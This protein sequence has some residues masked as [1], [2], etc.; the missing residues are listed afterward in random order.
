MQK[1][2]TL[3]TAVLFSV[4]CFAQDNSALDS[5]YGVLSVQS[6]VPAGVWLNGQAV[7]NTPLSIELSAGW[8]IYSVRAPGYWTEVFLTNIE[9]GAKISQDIH[10]KKSESPI[11]KI[12]GMHDVSAMNDLKELENLY[13]SLAN[14]RPAAVPDS[15]CMADFVANYPL[16]VEAPSPLNENSAEYRKYY[17]IYS[18]ER[19]LSFEEWYAGCLGPVQH[20]LNIVLMRINELGSRQISGIVPVVGANFESTDPNGLKGDLTLFFRSSDGRAEVAWKG[21]WENDFLTGSE[22]VKALTAS[23]PIALAFLTA[24][25]QTVWIPVEGGFSRHFY[26]YREFNLSWNALLI[27]MKGEFILPDYIIA[28]PGVMESLA[29]ALEDS[30]SKESGADEAF[31]AK[32]PG[33][34]FIYKGK[35]S[36]INPFSMNTKEISQGLYKT[37]CGK[38]DFGSLKGDSLP[39][40]S[41]TWK[42]A[43]SCCAAF[44]GDLPTEAEW[45]YAA[46]AGIPYKYVWPENDSAK[47]YAVF[48]GKKPAV[49]GSK[50]SNGWGLYDMFGNVAEWVKDDGFWYGKY[51]YL[52]GGSWK[53][54]EKDLSVEN[55]EEEDTRYWG[56]HTGF[57]CVF[58]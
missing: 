44:G 28:H 34:T 26:K 15:I 46:R 40:H 24:Q 6:S 10:L 29:Q 4:L 20:S 42:E 31:L 30:L 56:K 51:K 21:V 45:E 1:K 57:R 32:I 54:R 22:L 58:K 13:D 3:I 55:I 37:K 11:K 14:Q 53:S 39:A 23:P 35:I 36:N 9:Q 48:S 49:T 33:G 7:G 16:T 19:Q 52:K 18:N 47:N 5:S 43:N 38:K 12:F 41:V 8:A 17:E 25:N 50:K 27:P 2:T